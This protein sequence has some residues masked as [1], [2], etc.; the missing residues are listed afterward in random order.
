MALAGSNRTGLAPRLVEGVNVR[1]LPIGPEDAFVLSYV[2][3]VSSEADLAAATSLSLEAVARVVARLA[4]LGAI[5]FNAGSTV[6]V[7]ER[8]TRP[9]QSGAY[10]IGPIREAQERAS[11]HPAATRDSTPELDEPVDLD[12]AQKQVLLEA[13]HRLQ[14]VNH[15]ELLGAEPLEDAKALRARY[16][17]LVRVF[18]PDRYFGKNLGSYQAKL[19]RVFARLTEA[20]EVLRRSDT[21]AEYDRYLLAR[22]RTLAF[23]QKLYDD[24]RRAAEVAL[25]M[26]RI[27]DAASTESLSPPP[28]SG[29]LPASGPRDSLR[30]GHSAVSERHSSLPPSDPE[31]RRRALA[32][33]LGYSSAPPSRV[34]LTPAPP[35]VRA[36]ED[37]KRRYEHRLLRARD[38]QRNHYLSLASAAESSNDLAGAANALRIACSLAPEDDELA[39][40]L[41][42]LERRAASELWEAYAERGKY[43][44][45]EG[46]HAEAAES[47]ERAALGRPNASLFE[48]AAFYTLEAGGDLRHAS[49]LAKQ[50]VAL[51]PHSAK[52]HL[53][54]A[55]IYF[56]AK[57]RESALGELERARTLEPEHPMIKDWIQRAKR[58][59]V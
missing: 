22:G 40:R 15:Y 59:D 43:A 30:G 44:A 18:H 9:A 58:G 41:G 2:D 46:R 11:R 25:V 21:R 32:R 13:Y 33:K 53:T 38:E 34:S 57:L 35:S 19:G 49:Q 42:E 24:S 4:E 14:S 52:C 12:L 39:D 51:A 54:L 47:F 5:A 16:Y 7:V 55:Q 50:A 17:A 56:A 8:L 1:Q 3:G 26:Q 27:E 29:P 10:R 45:F 28:A 23:E 20:Y 36:A 31:A 6:P 48:R 37:L